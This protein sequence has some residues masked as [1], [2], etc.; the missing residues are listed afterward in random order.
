MLSSFQREK[1]IGLDGWTTK[2]YLGFFTLLRENLLR[3]MEEVR[4]NGEVLDS[5]N[6]TFISLI[7]KVDKLDFFDEFSPIALCNYVYMI[8]LKV[9]SMRLKKFLYV[10]ISPEW[11][12]FLKGRQIHEA[13]ESTHE[14]L[15]SI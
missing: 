4:L 5:F 15:H 14:V 9:L 8:I 13:I 12:N 10:F 2:F 3:S 6:T 1:S 7:Q 11:L